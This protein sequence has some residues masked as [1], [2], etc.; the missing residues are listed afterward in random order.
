[1]KDLELTMDNKPGA[2][3]SFGELLGKAGISLE[4]GGVFYNGPKAIAHFLMDEADRAKELLEE[5]G[6]LNVKTSDVIILK[7]RQDVAGQL[8]LLTRKMADAGVNILSQ[9]SDHA[10]QLVL[11]VD[12]H[13]KAEKVSADWMKTIN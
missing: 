10:N 9:Y 13:G 6:F 1:M 3:A 11:V 4:G 12:D 2:L 8:G 7:L 5:A